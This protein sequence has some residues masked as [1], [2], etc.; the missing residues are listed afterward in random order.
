LSWIRIRIRIQQSL[1]PFPFSANK[2][3]DPIQQSL[4]PFPDS[5]NKFLDPDS[6]H[7][8]PKLWLKSLKRKLA[9][10]NAGLVTNLL[11]FLLLQLKVD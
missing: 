5:A 4:G 10:W 6:V 11:L 1:G 3:L 9:L 8:N 7:H 2:F